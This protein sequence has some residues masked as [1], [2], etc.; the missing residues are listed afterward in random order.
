MHQYQIQNIN[1]FA[2]LGSVNISYSSCGLFYYEP[3]PIFLQ[4]DYFI[5]CISSTVTDKPNTVY[6]YTLSK[7]CNTDTYLVPKPFDQSTQLNPQGT[8][9]ELPRHFPTNSRMPRY[10]RI[11]IQLFTDTLFTTE[12]EVSTRGKTVPIYLL[13]I[14]YLFKYTTCSQ[15]GV[16]RY[17]IDGNCLFSITTK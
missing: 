13:V 11:E 14:G 3:E 16:P 12:I 10:G 8:N 7:L 17:T 9:N 4:I 15:T 1:F 2:S 6:Q 5:S